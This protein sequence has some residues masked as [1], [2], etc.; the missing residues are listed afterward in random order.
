[1]SPSVLGGRRGGAAVVARP[2][3]GVARVLGVAAFEED[4]FAVSVAAG[5][6]PAG[7]LEEGAGSSLTLDVPM[8][9]RW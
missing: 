3:P 4:R 8:A 1:M 2:P 6:V 9:G 5:A 7:S